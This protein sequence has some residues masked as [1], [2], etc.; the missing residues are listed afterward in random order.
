M[1]TLEKLSSLE[2]LEQRLQQCLSDRF[3]PDNALGVEC[4]LEDEK[5]K[6]WVQHD[7]ATFLEEQSAFAAL[8]AVLEGMTPPPSSQVR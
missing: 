6:V 3:S 8:Q 7:P 5:L 2:S 1:E 4:L